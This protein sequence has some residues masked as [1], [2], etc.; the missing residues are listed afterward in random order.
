MQIDP[1]L[2]EIDDCLYRVATKAIVVHGDKV[3]LVKEIPELWWGFPGG[4]VDHNETLETSLIRELVEELGIKSSDITT[5][6][7]IVHHTIGTIVDKIPRMNVFY[8]V[9]IKE[10]VLGK[11]DQVAEW[12]WVTRDEFMEIDMSPSYKDRSKLADVIFNK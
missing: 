3:L 12:Q 5:D 9:N 11:T 2:D 8:K 1:R 10:T 7:K 4:G 6:F